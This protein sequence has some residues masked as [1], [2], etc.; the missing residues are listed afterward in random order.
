[1]TY[2]GGTLS[3]VPQGAAGLVRTTD[4]DYLV[5]VTKGATLKVSYKQVNLLEYGQQVTRRYALAV[6]VSP[7][8]LLSKR[9]THFLT[10]GFTD[11][12]GQQQALVFTVAKEDIRVLLASLEAR[13]GRSVEF[14]DEEARRAGKG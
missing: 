7:M 2:A 9:R 13:T 12:E 4:P 5:M 14:Q 6:I 10:V 11:N 3:A 8:F 1:M